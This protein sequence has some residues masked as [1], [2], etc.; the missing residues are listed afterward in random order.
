M[1]ETAVNFNLEETW[2]STADCQGQTDSH[3]DIDISSSALSLGSADSRK[4]IYAQSN[5]A[6]ALL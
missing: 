5:T 4:H 2:A 3:V 6:F 1:I